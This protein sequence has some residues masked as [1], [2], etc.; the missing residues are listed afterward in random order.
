MYLPYDGLDFY[1]DPVAACLIALM[2]VAIVV[3]LSTDF[4][5]IRIRYR[6]RRYFPDTCPFCG[7]AAHSNH[8]CKESRY[9]RR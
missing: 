5:K 4:L 6:N 2:V 9:G 3:L 1:M 7:S 8:F